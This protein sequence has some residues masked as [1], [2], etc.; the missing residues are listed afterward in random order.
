MH[1][2]AQLFCLRVILR[3]PPTKLQAL[4]SNY[5]SQGA[6]WR[7]VRVPLSLLDQ[8]QPNTSSGVTNGCTNSVQPGDACLVATPPVVLRRLLNRLMHSSVEING[9]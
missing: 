9:I 1:A 2:E 5:L 6:L 7:S 3:I 8:R 4:K